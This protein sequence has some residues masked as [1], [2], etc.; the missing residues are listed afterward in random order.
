MN[1]AIRQSEETQKQ[2]KERLREER[3]GSKNRSYVVLW[4]STSRGTY[5]KAKHGPLRFPR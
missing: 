4:D 1:S 3:Q 2:Y 5:L